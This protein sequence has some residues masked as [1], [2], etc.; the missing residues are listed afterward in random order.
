MLIKEVQ[1]LTSNFKQINPIQAKYIQYPIREVILESSKFPY[2][3]L[4]ATFTVLPSVKF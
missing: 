1:V 2:R 4:H 3:K